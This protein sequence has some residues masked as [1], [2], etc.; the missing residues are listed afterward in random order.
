MI[1]HGACMGA[2]VANPQQ[3]EVVR[4][5]T[6]TGG[7]FPF[8][9]GF[10]LIR[11]AVDNTSASVLQTH[12]ERDNGLPDPASAISPPSSTGDSYVRAT[13][14]RYEIYIYTT[15]FPA[16]SSFP[17]LSAVWGRTFRK[18]RDAILRCTRRKLGPSNASPRPLNRSA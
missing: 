7:H 11:K 6:C 9:G 15:Q 8:Q 5:V 4:S 1:M 17:A 13:D 12:S 2:Y 3:T 14:P 10:L 16:V 18:Y